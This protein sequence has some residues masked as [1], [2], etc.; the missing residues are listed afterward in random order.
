MSASCCTRRPKN[1]ELP[2]SRFEMCKVLSIVAA[3]LALQAFANAEAATTTIVAQNSQKCLDVRGGPQ[4]TDD[5]VLIEQYSCT[6]SANQS[7][8][9]RD[10]GSQQYELVA[11][12]SYK[13]A[14]VIDKA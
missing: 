9:L 2:M 1:Q 14:S 7:W 5:N 11:S 13:C 10:M 6:G 12:N 3:V 8:E 4:A